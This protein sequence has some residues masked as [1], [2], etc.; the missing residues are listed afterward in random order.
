ML[1][2]SVFQFY[3]QRRVS[4]VA[5]LTTL[6]L[7]GAQ[8][9]ATSACSKV[10]FRSYTNFLPR[11]ATTTYFY[12]AP[13]CGQDRQEQ[14]KGRSRLPRDPTEDASLWSHQSLLSSII[15]KYLLYFFISTNCHALLLSNKTYISSY[16]SFIKSK[17]SLD[18][19]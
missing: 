14:G 9:E 5:S 19:I 11:A 18:N 7:D 4:P 15:V 10:V 16:N 3:R 17:N 1:Q 12:S 13:P 2:K 6:R 8:A